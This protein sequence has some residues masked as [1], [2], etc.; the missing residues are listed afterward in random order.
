MKT[1]ILGLSFEIRRERRDQLTS[2]TN[3]DEWLFEAMGA[4]PTFAGVKVSEQ[5]AMRATAVFAAV[6]I[7]A[8]G[9]ASLPLVLYER[10]K[11]GKRR[12]EEHPMYQLLHDAPN[13]LQ[14]SFTFRERVQT[15]LTLWGN[16]YASI[17][18]DGRKTAKELYSLPTNRV[19]PR[20][21]RGGRELVYDVTTDEKGTITLP[22][23]DILHIP[24]LGTDGISGFSPIAMARQAIGTLLATEEHAA[25]F[26]G[27]GAHFDIVL[28]TDSE[29]SD[30][31]YKR[32]R[33][34]WVKDQEGLGNVYRTPILEGGLKVKP[35][36][37]PHDDAQFLETRKFQVAEI[38]RIYNL[39]PHLLRE[40][41]AATYTNIEHQSL[42][43]VIFSLMPWLKRWEQELNRKLLTPEE[44]KRYFFE[45]LVDGLLRGDIKTRHETYKTG[46]QS[47]YYSINDILEMENRPLLEGKVGDVHFMPINMVPV[48]QSVGVAAGSAPAGE[49][50]GNGATNNRPAGARATPLLSRKRLQRAYGQIFSSSLGW[51]L[52]REIRAARRALNTSWNE[53]DPE[54]FAKWVTDFYLDNPHYVAGAI[55]PALR[56]YAELLAGCVTDDELIGTA[57][58]DADLEKFIFGFGE[59]WG[60]QHSE[61]SAR[62]LRTLLEDWPKDKAALEESAN[63]IFNGWW[64]EDALEGTRCDRDARHQSSCFANSIVL[65][66]YRRAG[67]KRV[68]WSGDY[69]DECAPCKELD[70]KA[71]EIGK[72]FR[73]QSGLEL[74]HPPIDVDCSCP[75]GCGCQVSAEQEKETGK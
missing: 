58:L 75:E 63:R 3:P 53:H 72:A 4:M 41:G 42:E 27:R 46:I 13:P 48:E 71:V 20:L 18:R 12:A 15:W 51:V 28:E 16:G 45:F 69:H 33:K 74:E 37:M 57:E 34:D 59:G 22:R 2:F 70:G 19:R 50:N 49:G 23:E 61:T 30:V 29:L 54:K 35:I 40:M 1:N 6:R 8:E 31:A 9:V 55:Q 73:L 7:Y 5:T 44:R 68:R 60:V 56:S 24:G 14:T 26:F 65:R 38:A 11:R 67:I 32:V 36:T 25:R 62:Q 66:C 43:Y 17:A 47:S 39:P 10:M 52:R 21:L 64:Q